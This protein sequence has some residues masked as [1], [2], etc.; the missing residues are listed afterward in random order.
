MKLQFIFEKELEKINLIFALMNQ[1]SDSSQE[2]FIPKMMKRYEFISN[3]TNYSVERIRKILNVTRTY[4]YYKKGKY[5]F[6]IFYYNSNIWY[7]NW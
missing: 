5:S 1:I 2:N 3:L 4:M 7:S 6:K